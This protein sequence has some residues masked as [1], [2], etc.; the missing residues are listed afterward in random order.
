MLNTKKLEYLVTYIK[1]KLMACYNSLVKIM[2]AFLIGAS[3]FDTITKHVPPICSISMLVLFLP[4]I[5]WFG[6]M[7][8]G[9]LKVICGKDNTT[10]DD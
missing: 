3:I 8:R 6:I 4:Q 5:Y 9:G 10:K 7:L 1:V 2:F